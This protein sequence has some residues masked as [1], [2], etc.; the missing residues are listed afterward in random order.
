MKVKSSNTL[1]CTS[2]PHMVLNMQ[3]DQLSTRSYIVSGIRICVVNKD[4][5][6]HKDRSCSY[7]QGT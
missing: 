7:E 6:F 2:F 4:K 3:M 1:L 5:G